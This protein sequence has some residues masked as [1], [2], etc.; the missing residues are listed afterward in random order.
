M[1]DQVDS[2][3]IVCC[4]AQEDYSECKCDLTDDECWKISDND[5]ELSS[6]KLEFV[7]RRKEG[8]AGEGGTVSFSTTV[9]PR[10]N[11]NLGGVETLSKDDYDRIG[12]KYQCFITIT[13]NGSHWLNRVSS[14]WISALAAFLLFDF[15]SSRSGCFMPVAEVEA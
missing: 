9:N 15:N 8:R 12:A 4:K 11:G 1:I 3:K 2:F 10:N 14:R 5:D 7:M 13:G 6:V